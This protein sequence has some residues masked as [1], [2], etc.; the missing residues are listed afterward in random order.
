VAVPIYNFGDLKALTRAYCPS[1]PAP[2]SLLQSELV[3]WLDHA[4]H[5]AAQGNDDVKE[6]FLHRYI[7]LLQ[8][9]SG[10]LLPAVQADALIGIAR[11]L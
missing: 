9:A 3:R 1:D 11:T 7:G 6:K 2:A 5:A 8:K 4:A 10:R